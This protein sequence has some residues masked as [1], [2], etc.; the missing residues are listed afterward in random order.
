MANPTTTYESG[1][2]DIVYPGNTREERSLQENVLL[3]RARDY[4]IHDEEIK[5]LQSYVGTAPNAGWQV[6][7][8]TLTDRVTSIGGTGS[9]PEGGTFCDYFGSSGIDPQATGYIAMTGTW[10]GDPWISPTGVFG[11]PNSPGVPGLPGQPPPPPVVAPPQP[12]PWPRPGVEDT[13]GGGPKAPQFPGD[14]D[15]FDGRDFFPPGEPVEPEWAVLNHMLFQNFISEGLSYR[16]NTLSSENILLQP[17]PYTELLPNFKDVIEMWDEYPTSRTKPSVA[18]RAGII[19]LLWP[20]AG[21][22]WQMAKAMGLQW[23]KGTISADG[24]EIQF[25]TGSDTLNTGTKGTSANEIAWIGSNFNHS[26][27]TNSNILQFRTDPGDV[28]VTAQGLQ[29]AGVYHLLLSVA[30]PADNRPGGSAPA[31]VMVGVF[32]GRPCLAMQGDATTWAVE[33]LAV[34]ADTATAGFQSVDSD[35][36]GAGVE[37]MTV[38]AGAIGAGVVL[39]DSGGSAPNS[40]EYQ[41]VGLTR[42]FNAADA[43]TE[44]QR[45]ALAEKTLTS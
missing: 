32:T 27:L 11:D 26:S 44:V 18:D 3:Q 20:L 34:A 12:V 10:F 39:K 6:G 42:N 36:N 40:G 8:T 16:I 43:I 24:L 38:V 33:N 2:P 15:G 35:I 19:D 1:F 17:L 21:M 13:H 9:C 5:A 25:D 31:E 7:D 41:V 29:A 23:Y 37:M 30:I 45:M 14:G 28:N 4:N 22:T